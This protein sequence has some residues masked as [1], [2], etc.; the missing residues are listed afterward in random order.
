MAKDKNKPKVHEELDGLNIKIDSFGEMSS[1]MEIDKI[2]KFLN[3][4]VSDRKLTER[5]EEP[6]SKKKK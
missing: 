3:E 1:N 6:K 5:N 4:K 2:N